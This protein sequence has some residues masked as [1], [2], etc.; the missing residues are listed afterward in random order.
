[1]KLSIHQYVRGK[2][3]TRMV[4]SKPTHWQADRRVNLGYDWFNIDASWPDVFEVITT[5]GCASSAELKNTHRHDDDF[6]SRQL[7]FIDIDSGM[8]IPELLEND[9]Y[10]QHGAGFYTTPSHTQDSHRFRIM[11][12]TET[13]ITDGERVK[14]LIMALMRVFDHADPACKDSTRIF[15]GTV[16]AQLKERRD[17]ILSDAWVELL[18]VMEDMFR[19]QQQPVSIAIDTRQY[20]PKSLDQIEELLN[21]LRKHY[22]DLNYQQR[23]DVTWAV[24]S[25][26]SNPDTVRLLRS[27]WDDSDKTGRYE[28]FVNARKS[29]K[30]TIGTIYHMIRQRDPGYARPPPLRLDSNTGSKI[31][32]GI[33]AIAILQQERYKIKGIIRNG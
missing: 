14:K 2:P 12:V 7:L 19:A 16:A 33:D 23:R 21:Q 17:I 27:R 10:N 15:Y 22:A 4:D 8:T 5:M 6:V 30:I 24:A 29:A 9:F 11:F 20:L 32:T 28:M 31:Y 3:E 1:M 26:V 25:Q 18:V 13:A